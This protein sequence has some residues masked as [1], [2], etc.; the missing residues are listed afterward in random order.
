MIVYKTTNLVNGKIYVGS[1][2]NNNEKYLGSGKIL[3]QSIKKYNRENFKKEV[4]Q[5]CNSLEELKTSESYWIKK[6]K[7]NVRGIG[8][9]ISSNYF[10]GDVFT[11]HPNK[12]S[13]REKLKKIN[14]GESNPM[15][16]KSVFQHWVE[17]YGEEIAIQKQNVKSE[18]QRIAI[19]GENNPMKLK[20]SYCRWV[21]KY[22]EEIAI[23]KQNNLNEKRKIN[24]KGKNNAN[25]KII[26]IYENE[27]LIARYNN[28]KEF[29][30]KENK[31]AH[32]VRKY[33]NKK[34]INNKD[35]YWNNKFIK[36]IK[37]KDLKMINL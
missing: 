35:N 5:F 9:N 20:N 13:Y 31:K 3:K 6:L 32:F 15:F 7:S 27:T 37:L 11:N 14:S 26:E 16:G 22:G 1:D 29:T 23:Q 30:I 25:S 21:E 12:E 34:I 33:Q 28:L 2:K 18:K 36:V 19:S 17:K 24:A 8:Y 4:L 10:G